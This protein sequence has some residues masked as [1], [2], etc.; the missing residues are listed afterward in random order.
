MK[1]SEKVEP[2]FK[3]ITPQVAGE[4]AVLLLKAA[5]ELDALFA[6]DFVRNVIEHHNLFGQDT[7]RRFLK[8]QGVAFFTC[9]ALKVY[10]R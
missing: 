3:V 2:S 10:K 6:V 7:L 8:G 5:D 1:T 9:K 4:A